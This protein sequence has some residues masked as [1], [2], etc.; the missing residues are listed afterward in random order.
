[1]ALDATSSTSAGGVSCCRTSGATCTAA[2]EGGGGGDA[3][4]SGE[5]P[6]T[7]RLLERP[8]GHDSGAVLAGWPCSPWCSPL[9]S[10]Y[11]VNIM[12]T[13]L[14]YVVLGLGL[15]IVVGLAG[16]L[17]LGY[18][19]FYAVG[20]YSYALLNLHFG[21]VASGSAIPVGMAIGAAVRHPAGHPGAAPARRLPGDRHPGLRRDHP[22][23]P[24]E[25]ERLL[26]RPE[27]HRQHP[28]AEPLRGGAEPA[29]DAPMYM[30]YL[31]IG[32]VLFTVFVVNRLQ[33]SRLGPLLGGAA[34]GRHRL[35]GHGHRPH[36]DQARGL[37]PG[38]H[39][40]RHGP[41]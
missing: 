33:N 21:L 24:R 41:G 32:L 6:C 7:Q 14:I 34:R 12:I 23:R 2:K 22:P 30:Y 27:R 4:G 11:Q 20:A 1:M 38:G 15:N 35:P 10:S 3:T 9:F 5:T 28:A 26:L 29:A 37:R 16:L 39:L 13:A 8:A 17:D 25:L 31:M 40:G 19:A 36:E 18:V